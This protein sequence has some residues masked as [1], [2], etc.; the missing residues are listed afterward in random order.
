MT[1]LI[2]K[3]HWYV[4]TCGYEYNLGY[5]SIIQ[6]NILHDAYNFVYVCK[7]VCLV[8]QYFRLFQIKQ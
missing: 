6:R 7:C 8:Q 2:H 5:S 4:L 1:K 3:I